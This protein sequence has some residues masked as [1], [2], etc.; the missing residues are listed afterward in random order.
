LPKQKKNAPPATDSAPEEPATLRL[1]IRAEIIREETPESTS[2]PAHRLA[3]VPVIGGAAVLITLGWFAVSAFRDDSPLPSNA[4]EQSQEAA[5]QS[6]PAT[7]STP[8]ASVASEDP[9]RDSS[10]AAAQPSNATRPV[11]ANSIDTQTPSGSSQTPNASALPTPINEV[12]PNA[13]PSALQTIRGTIRVVVRVEIDKQ[14]TVVAAVSKIP[15]P[16]KYFERL[17]LEASRKWTFKPTNAVDSHTALLRFS[18]R[19]DGVTATA[20]P[21]R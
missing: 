6:P 4:T 15:G 1:V 5:V 17:S 7:S 3:L 9:P 10:T 8:V 20:E 16:S 19:R 18:F 12:T 2:A 11:E 14:G 21:V 13:S